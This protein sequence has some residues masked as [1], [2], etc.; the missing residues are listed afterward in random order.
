MSTA[1]A[2]AERAEIAPT[3][4]LNPLTIDTTAAA[5]ARLDDLV[6]GFIDEATGHVEDEMRRMMRRREVSAAVRGILQTKTDLDRAVPQ[7][8]EMGIP[9]IGT[10]SIDGE[11]P[12]LIKWYKTLNRAMPDAEVEKAVDAILDPYREQLKPKAT[13]AK[14]K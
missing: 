13:K 1:V 3:K 8:I 11:R 10:A 14:G 9:Q 12:D 7:S 4:F 5:V 6:T 2:T